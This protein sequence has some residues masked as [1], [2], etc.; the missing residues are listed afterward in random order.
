MAI[1]DL[2]QHQTLMRNLAKPDAWPD[3]SGVPRLIQTHISSVV[4]AGACAYKVKKPLD[5]GFLD[6]ST[7]EKRHEA[8]R[9]EVRLNSRLAPELYLGVVPITGSA[10]QPSVD[11]DG[12]PID[13]AVQMRRF[14]PA[15]VLDQCPQRIDDSLIDRLAADI[16]GFHRNAEVAPE[17]YGSPAAVAAAVDDNIRQI[18]ARRSAERA[19][20]DQLADWLAGQQERLAPLL[21]ARQAQGHIRECH[22]DLHL[23]NIVLIDGR[24]VIF[25]GIEFNPQLRYID[26]LSDLAFLTMDLARLGRPDQAYRLLDRYLAVTGDFAG[27]PLLRLY[28]VYRA[29]VR[30]KVAAIHAGERNLGADEREH[31]VA[32]LRRYL[33]VATRLTREPSPALV[34]THGVSGAGKSTASDLLVAELSAIRV[35]SDVERKRLAAGGGSVNA[36]DL[37]G[38]GMTTRT[39]DRLYALA[40][41][42]IDAGYVAVV[43]ATFLDARQRHRFAGLA[44]E[45]AVPFAILA[46]QAPPAELARRV[47]ARSRGGW[48]VSD[49]DGAVVARQLAAEGALDSQEQAAAVV[50]SPEQPLDVEQLCARL[51]G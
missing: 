14:D 42:I 18:R 5:L 21:A 47:G 9:Q 16:A 28:E 22:G 41:G 37:Y 35:R 13:W 46:C 26:V 1:S 33:R 50:V 20:L 29:M 32:L 43:D 17:D 38:E 31:I 4:L 23:N 51:W 12:E 10:E 36:A 3:G 49:A 11:G 44:A 30:A 19:Q 27:L 40:A 2:P 34:I 15:A 39:Y 48:D 6:F 8:C 24:P 7:L 45:R 25:D